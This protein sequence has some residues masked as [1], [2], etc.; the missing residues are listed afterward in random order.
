MRRREFITLFGS[1]ATALLTRWAAFGQDPGRVYR[2]GVLS[3]IARDS[4]QVATFFDELRRAG[5]VEGRNLV[6]AAGG[7]GLRPDDFARHA[8]IIAGSDVD[9]VYTGGDTGIRIAQEA[10]RTLP[11]VG[12]TEDMVGAG[13]ARTLA[14]PGGNI[15]GVSLLAAD[16]N[17]K[18]MEILLEAVPGARLVAV[19]ADVNMIA[20]LQL[21][22]LQDA[23]RSRG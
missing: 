15:T 1:A 12:I 13:F 17:G 6:V 11:I 19:L 22:V 14:H 9:V 10:M 16:L 7:H 18:R 21:Q 8:D 3:A 20:P 2:L 4:P 23:A 5:F